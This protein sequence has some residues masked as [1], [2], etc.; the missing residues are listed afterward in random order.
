[1]AGTDDTT[2]E[3]IIH[4]ANAGAGASGPWYPVPPLMHAA[5]Q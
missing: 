3:S 5:A 4:A 2:E 1:M